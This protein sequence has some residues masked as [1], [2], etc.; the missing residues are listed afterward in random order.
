MR[1]PGFLVGALVSALLTVVL[2]ALLFFIH[3]LTGLPFIPFAI[4]DGFSRI[5]PGSL[6]TRGID[7]MVAAIRAL[8]LGETSTVAKLAEQTLAIF[9][10]FLTG[11]IAG[12][13]F[14]RVLRGRERRL[15]LAYGLLTGGVLGVVLAAIAA[16]G[17]IQANA[18]W[19]GLALWVLLVFLA[20]G[21]ALGA[22][23]HRLTQPWPARAGETERVDRRRFLLRFAT[24]AAGVALGAT[25]LGAI[26]S[27][28]LRP[29]HAQGTPWSATHP[30][31]NA[32]ARVVPAAGTR[33]EFTPVEDHYR[34]DI[35]TIPP[36]VDA[37]SWRLK[38]SGLVSQPREFTLGQLQ[39]FPSLD[40]FITL[41]CISNPLGGD[42]ISTTRWTG[43]S[44]QHLITRFALLPQAT[45]LRLHS[46]DGF[47]EVIALD[48][49][50]SDPRIMLTYAWDGLPLEDKHGFPLRIYIP[51]HYGMKQPKWIESIEAID[52]WQP[53]YWV[54]RGWDRDARMKATSV[55]DTVSSDMMIIEPGEQKTVPIG[56]IAHAGAR[57]ISRVEVRVDDGPWQ[58]ALL[59]D[60]LSST[61][62]VLWRYDWPFT[63]GRH[64]FTVR[65]FEADGT[66]Q[67]EADAPI[68]PSGASG[69]HSVTQVL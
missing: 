17:R 47:H 7:T 46:V 60:P 10:C 61:T 67:I 59:R 3:A 8:H 6:V 2:L 1:R 25:A 16:I 39:A 57:G 42:L 68:R 69:L 50:R 9:G 14:F 66:P 19:V 15:W 41:S 36:Q 43:V 24:M 54:S 33:H 52:A 18:P 37:D 32:N 64:T 55:I 45:H 4:F 44:L 49:I 13:L 48:L 34:I 26:L 5:L 30:L 28:L 65:C 62:W 23:H 38:V 20:W 63:P 29:R 40:Q 35:N 11:T 27:R 58:P 31:P 51:D 21:A 12:G 53:G 22:L 56:G